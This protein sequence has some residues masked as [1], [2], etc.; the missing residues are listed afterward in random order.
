M[1][2]RPLVYVLLGQCG[3]ASAY[4]QVAA[5]ESGL[6]FESPAGSYLP[7]ATAILRTAHRAFPQLVQLTKQ[8]ASTPSPSHTTTPHMMSALTNGSAMTPTLNSALTAGSAMTSSRNIPASESLRN[9]EELTSLSWLQ[10][11]NLLKSEYRLYPVSA[12]YTRLVHA[13]LG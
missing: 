12:G 4:R 11:S 2:Q 8:L 1:I 9:D 10:D 13:I 3:D 6:E 7:T 5:G